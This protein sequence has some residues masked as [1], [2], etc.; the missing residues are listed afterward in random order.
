MQIFLCCHADVHITETAET[1]CH[2][3]NA[4]CT[5]WAQPGLYS[6][7]GECASNQAYMHHVCPMS[8]GKCQVSLE[9]TSPCV[10]I[11]AHCT[12]WARPGQVSKEGECVNNKAFMKRY[13]RLSCDP[14]CGKAWG[15][16]GAVRNSSIE[17]NLNYES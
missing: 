15:F 2:D 16:P 5:E 17:T 1:K 14:A 12:K 7:Y 13:C 4:N 3:F 8:C 10:D 9:V 6:K 11:Y